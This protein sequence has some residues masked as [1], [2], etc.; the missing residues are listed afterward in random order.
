M[1]KVRVVIVGDFQC[2][3][4]QTTWKII[5]RYWCGTCKINSQYEDVEKVGRVERCTT[6]AGSKFS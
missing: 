6:K 5:F 4:F 2:Y 1:R 3:N